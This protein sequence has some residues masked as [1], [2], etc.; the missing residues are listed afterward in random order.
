M[1]HCFCL[2]III[3]SKKQLE[4]LPCLCS[5]CGRTI[6]TLELDSQTYFCGALNRCMIE[7][8]APTSIVVEDCCQVRSRI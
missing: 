2:P 6:A 7:S 1:A 8:G 4:F 3:T 5:H